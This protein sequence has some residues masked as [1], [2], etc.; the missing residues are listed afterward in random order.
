MVLLCL[1]GLEQKLFSG[2]ILILR[3]MVAANFYVPNIYRLAIL[4]L[5]RGILFFRNIHIDRIMRWNTDFICDGTFLLVNNFSFFL[6]DIVLALVL[7]FSGSFASC[8][9]D[10]NR[11]CWWVIEPPRCNPLHVLLLLLKNCLFLILIRRCTFCDKLTYLIIEDFYFLNRFEDVILLW[12]YCV[13]WW[14]LRFL[15][16]SS[17]CSVLRLDIGRVRILRQFD[18][19]SQSCQLGSALFVTSFEHENFT[20]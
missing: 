20:D 3:W 9:F 12:P 17:A 1:M 4:K 16:F 19:A 5:D 18:N 2:V 7:I 15:A 13:L 8:D 6:K 14:N 11:T 10:L